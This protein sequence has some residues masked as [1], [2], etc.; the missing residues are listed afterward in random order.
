M[1]PEGKTVIYISQMMSIFPKL[2]VELQFYKTL[3][4]IAT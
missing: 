1:L 4:Y 2:N 3:A